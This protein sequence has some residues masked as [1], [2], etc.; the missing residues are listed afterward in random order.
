M[1]ILSPAGTISAEGLSQLFLCAIMLRH[2]MPH[3]II[4]DYDP[5]STLRVWY[6]LVSVLGCEHAKSSSHHPEIDR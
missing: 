4:L 6:A 5:R 1:Y 3:R 2:G